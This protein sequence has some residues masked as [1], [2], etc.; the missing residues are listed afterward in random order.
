VTFDNWLGYRGNSHMPSPATQWAS[1]AECE[2]K[3]HPHSCIQTLALSTAT[4]LHRR[5]KVAISA[6]IRVNKPS[7]SA[8]P[9]EQ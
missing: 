3:A 1:S 7:H 4:L 6:L 2:N 8:F 5:K 9:R